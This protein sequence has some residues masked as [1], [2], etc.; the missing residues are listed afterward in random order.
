M[1]NRLEVIDETGRPYVNMNVQSITQ[2][3][4]DDWRTL[5][6]FVTTR[7]CQ[8]CEWDCDFICWTCWRWIIKK[9]ER[10]FNWTTLTVWTKQ[11]LDHWIDFVKHEDIPKERDEF[12]LWCTAIKEWIYPIDLEFASSGRHHPD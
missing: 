11:T 9:E 7:Q 2:S 10:D 12:L 4:Q 3:E 5:K 8:E 1:I 6:I